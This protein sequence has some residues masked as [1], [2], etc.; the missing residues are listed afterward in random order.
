MKNR[1]HLFKW[2]FKTYKDKN[3]ELCIYEHN[4]EIEAEILKSKISISYT[5]NIF[6]KIK[7]KLINLTYDNN[8]CTFCE[9]YEH[10]I[11]ISK[12]IDILKM[13]IIINKNMSVDRDI[14]QYFG[15]AIYRF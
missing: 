14:F 9:E 5:R 11:K 7:D 1:Y 6:N 8:K 15:G 12:I 13:L 10:Y 4:K 3:E 2:Y